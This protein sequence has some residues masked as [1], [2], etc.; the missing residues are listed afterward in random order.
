MNQTTNNKR[1]NKRDFEVLE[2]PLNPIKLEDIMQELERLLKEVKRFYLS[3]WVK[4]GDL[5]A[6]FLALLHYFN[7]GKVELKQREPFGD[8]EVLSL[9]T[10]G[11]P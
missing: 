5:P 3:D 6:K 4:G 9:G 1:K 8:I 11:K 2:F 7:E 10:A